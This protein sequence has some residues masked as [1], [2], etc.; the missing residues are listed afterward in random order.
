MAGPQLA[1][2]IADPRLATEVT[3]IFMCWRVCATA[4][5]EKLMIFSRFRQRLQGLKGYSPNVK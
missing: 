4:L 1:T 5:V 3:E 2:E